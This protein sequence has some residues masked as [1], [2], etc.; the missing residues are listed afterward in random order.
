MNNNNYTH[1]HNK[2]KESWLILLQCLSCLMLIGVNL[3][4]KVNSVILFCVIHYLCIKKSVFVCLSLQV[5]VHQSRTFFFSREFLHSGQVRYINRHH[6]KLPCLLL[7]SYVF[8]M[9][10]CVCGLSELYV[11]T[12][13]DLNMFLFVTLITTSF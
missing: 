11:Y 12:V 2:P 1:T 5:C 4:N 8:S 3:R 9:C 10:V 6:F 7:L 13:S